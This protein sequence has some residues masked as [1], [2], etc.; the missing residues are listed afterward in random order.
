MPR[1]QANWP[2]GS[3]L[4]VRSRRWTVVARTTFA[5]C[6]ALRLRPT[7]SRSEEAD[8]TLLLPFDRPV[9]TNRDAPLAVVRPRRWLHTLKR[10]AALS[11]PWG[12]LTAAATSDLQ[13][14]PYQLEP[15][16][17]MLRHGVTRVLVADAVGLGK[18]IQA[19]L[20]LSELSAATDTF[21]GLVL[22]PAGLLAQWSGELSARF[23]LRAEVADAAWLTRVARDLPPGLNPW[24]L[25]RLYLSSFDFVKRPE[26]LQALEDIHWTIVVV[27]EAHGASAG[28]ARRAAVHA[29]AVRATRVLLL[30]AT[31]HNGDP[32]RF[33]AL[34]RIGEAPAGGDP[35]MIFQRSRTNAG[36]AGSRRTVLLPI[37]PTG[38]EQRMHRLLDAYT[39]RLWREASRRGDDRARLAAVV[40]RKRALSSAGSLETSVRRRMALL[41]Q[42]DAPLEYQPGLPLAP[43]A[44]A[45]ECQEDEE[46][47]ALLSAPGLA[48]LSR[49]HGWL[50]SIADRA[51][52]AASA[53]S[54]IGA[55]I[56]LLR[57]LRR[58]AIVFTEFRDT[59]QRLCAA[60]GT[61]GID[62][63]ALHGG[64][65]QSERSDAQ[66][67]FQRGRLVL[68]ATDTASE[69]LNLQHGCHVVVH[70]ELPWSPARL[71]QRTGRVD[72]IGQTR[73]VHEIL[74]VAD[75]TAERLVL[76]P[77]FRRAG[78]GRTAAPFL[79]R[80]ATV[81]EESRVATAVMEGQDLGTDPVAGADIPATSCVP[82]PASLGAEAHAE[83]E[84]LRQQRQWLP[85]TRPPSRAP[86]RVAS[87]VRLCG[88]P[89][90]QGVVGIYAVALRTEG[91][92]IVD[93]RLI[94]THTRGVTAAGWESAA[95]I[96]A[97]ALSFF[98][99]R[100]GGGRA[101]V[102][103]GVSDGLK[104]AA[105]AHL[106]AIDALERRERS[107]A[108]ALPSAAGQL[109]QAGLFDT[110]A[111]HADRVRRED[112]GARGDA[113]RERLRNLE[114]AR[115]LS[116]T[117]DLIAVLLVSGSHR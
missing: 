69:G 47:G 75:D 100:D 15:A 102:M 28:T 29:V 117:C 38:D 33:D 65:S 9:A 39:A 10:A 87:A 86:S 81:L 51:H 90:P 78:R 94:C 70:F 76:A 63:V 21:R 45:A 11:H 85:S 5:D 77:L 108:V 101:A 115:Q 88:S 64:L 111:L 74:L 43:D 19:A 116:T 1:F 32:D 59:L 34:C 37:R 61:A 91:G 60:A 105:T 113:S 52:A 8:R 17:A 7:L 44:D 49:E 55:L 82:A 14:H 96:R 50:A 92:A 40:L 62:V 97:A 26:V 25:P 48:D 99:D 104:D 109:V 18:T 84:R 83:V 57:R 53:E 98:D 4:R 112:A 79:G 6:A 67:R 110:R 107:L 71:E 12:G 31:P 73:K 35:L 68:M 54:K 24:T 58:P 95:S 89:V 27:D 103:A 66:R 93:R 36:S 114:G 106:R 22:A 3:A 72:R 2:P 13:L 16:L 41:A 30:T 42:R 56:R 46:P 23:S 20:I 80:I